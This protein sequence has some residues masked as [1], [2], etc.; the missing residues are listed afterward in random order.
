MKILVRFLFILM[1][2]IEMYCYWFLGYEPSNHSV[3]SF[4]YVA[5][6]TLDK[7]FE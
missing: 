4:I 2:V 1:F 3:I 5:W 6:F 7:G